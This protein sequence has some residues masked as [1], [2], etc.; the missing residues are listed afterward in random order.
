[1]CLCLD[2]LSRHRA[3]GLLALRIAIGV[4][5]VYHGFLKWP[6]SPGAPW[7]MTLAAFVEPA[8]G[9]LL[10]L[11]LATR[12]AAIALSV[13]MLGAIYLKMTAFGNAPLNALGTFSP[14]GGGGWEFDLVILAACVSLVVSGAGRFAIDCCLCCG[15][16]GNTSA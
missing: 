3:W 10:I 4:V 12:W 6:L 2:S 1:M 13:V 14:Q 5:F 11:G 15:K 8:A 7:Y 16:K 9:L